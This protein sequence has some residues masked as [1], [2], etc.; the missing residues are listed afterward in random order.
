MVD[1]SKKNTQGAK[2]TGAF[3][4]NTNPLD[5]G[6]RSAD[7]I[8]IGE[9]LG[10]GASLSDNNSGFTKLHEEFNVIKRE[11]PEDLKQF[12]ISLISDPELD[13]F[14]DIIVVSATLNQVMYA[15]AVLPGDSEV[16]REYVIGSNDTDKQRVAKTIDSITRMD[17]KETGIRPFNALLHRNLC[18]TNEVAKDRVYL[19]NT[20]PVRS[21][22]EVRPVDLL[23]AARFDIINY[24]A[25]VLGASN[26]PAVELLSKLGTEV[27]V[28][29][30]RGIGLKNIVGTPQFSPV[31]VATSHKRS[32][33]FSGGVTN[34]RV[35]EMRGYMDALPLEVSRAH[36]LR[37][38]KANELGVALDTVEAPRLKPVFV[39][40]APEWGSRDPQATIDGMLLLGFGSLGFLASSPAWLINS[41][42]EKE[43]SGYDLASV[44]YYAT[45][46][47]AGPVA[48][49]HDRT[50][51]SDEARVQKHIQAFWDSTI[52]AVDVPLSGPGKTVLEALGS[53]DRVNKMLQ[54]VY[55]ANAILLQGSP[56]VTTLGSFPVGVYRDKGVLRHTNALTNAVAVATRYQGDPN[57]VQEFLNTFWRFD[58]NRAD[59]IYAARL[60][61]LQD[62]AASSELHVTGEVVR[63]ILSDELLTV[64]K[65]NFVHAKTVNTHNVAAATDATSGFGGGWGEG[66]AQGS[67]ATAQGNVAFSGFQNNL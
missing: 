21:A 37:L 7:S 23:R 17:D 38:K 55:G 64:A 60:K 30:I 67:A 41:I 52:V 47:D 24:V 31:V 44:G 22:Q 26:R 19:C 12:S 13:A 14:G 53:R 18:K 28:D 40:S 16:V 36:S 20:Y 15:V 43:T 32:Q 57:A 51:L 29:V 65:Q 46:V 8:D 58:A 1:V 3:S 11:N 39:A 49:Y 25:A 48:L 61:C 50:F 9:L 59:A 63:L 62:Y 45:G 10:G 4:A 66:L 2:D 5:T 34:Q 33:A 42:A 56:V 6:S 54:T 35:V 27:S